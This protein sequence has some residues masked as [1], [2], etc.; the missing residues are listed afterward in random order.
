MRGQTPAIHGRRC[1]GVSRAGSDPRPV[2]FVG[3]SFS[4]GSSTLASP[5]FQAA[6]WVREG[7]G[8]GPAAA[9]LG[10]SPRRI[11]SASS[12]V[13]ARAGPDL[14]PAARAPSRGSSRVVGPPPGQP[15]ALP[16]LGEQTRR[17]EL[18]APKFLTITDNSSTRSRE[19]STLMIQIHS[20]HGQDLFVTLNRYQS[21]LHSHKLSL[22]IIVTMNHY[23]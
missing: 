3:I 7:G 16:A 18:E 21:L 19:V 5:G 17:R 9:G 1:A 22:C 11:A 2:E 6:R 4:A 12:T 14:R 15:G 20:E 8:Q 10:S 13:G 23:Q